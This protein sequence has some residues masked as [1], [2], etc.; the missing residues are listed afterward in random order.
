[1][2]WS[3][4]SRAATTGCRARPTSSGSAEHSTSCSGVYAEPVPTSAPLVKDHGQAAP[5]FAQASTKAPAIF[6]VPGAGCRPNPGAQAQPTNVSS[7]M[8][9]ISLAASGRR[10]A[11]ILD[12]GT[13]L[14]EPLAFPGHRTR[15]QMPVRVA[16]H[17]GRLEIGGLMTDRAAHRREPEPVL[18]ALDRRL[19]QAAEIALVRA[20]ARRD[21]SSRSAGESAP[22]RVQ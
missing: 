6:W 15:R 16:R 10:C 20:I 4:W 11:R 9:C 19:V 2:S 17:A 3:P 8:W 22:C 12:L 7:P 21:D 13:D 18:P 5:V 14:A 1:M